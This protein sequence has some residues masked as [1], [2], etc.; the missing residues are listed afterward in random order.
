MCAN[1]EQAKADLKRSLDIVGDNTSFCYPFYSYSDT[2]IQAV[3]D[4]G[5][6]VAFAGGSRD[7]TRNDNKYIIPRYPI[8]SN[9]TMDVFKRI[10]N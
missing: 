7:A 5:F 1:Y 10:V 4:L 6:K 8:H 3:K 9:I 2:A